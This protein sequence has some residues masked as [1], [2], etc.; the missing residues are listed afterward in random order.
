MTKKIFLLLAIAALCLAACQKPPMLTLNGPTNL[1]ISVTGG[2]SPLTFTANKDWTVRASDSWVHVNPASGEG[3]KNA[4]TVTVT[5]DPNTS[6]D[7]R[8]ATV[9]I[10]SEGLTQAITIKQPAANGL[11]ASPQTINLEAGASTFEVEVQ[12]NVTYQVAIGASW[13][14]QT[15]TKALTS[16]KIV[17]S[18]EAN[19]AFEERSTTITIS[20]GNLASQVINVKQAAAEDPAK[21]LYGAWQMGA[22]ALTLN[23]GGTFSYIAYA[24][25]DEQKGTWTYDGENLTR[26]YEGSTDKEIAKVVLAGEKTW[27]S[28]VREDG[29]GEYRSRFY[30]NY[31]KKGATVLSGTLGDGRWD[32]PRNGIRPAENTISTSYT[33]CMVVEGSTVDLYV[34]AWGY[35]IQGTFTLNDGKM[36][37]ETDDDHIWQGLYIDRNGEYG[38][39]GWSA[40][41]PPS[42]EFESTWDYSYDSM[43]AETFELQYPY[44]YMSVSEVLAQGKK[45]E[46][47]D[48][49]YQVHPYY[50][51]FLIY[52]WGENMREIAYDLRDFDLC[53]TP[54]GTEA[55][56]G[57]IG[58]SPWLYKR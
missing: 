18:A 11:I 48:P 20:G 43:N 21:D 16:T 25:A 32:A 3:A 17:F 44:K 55:F 19:T 37:I 24:D 6:Y 12:A 10:S 4:I 38:S 27:L 57:A 1:E 53:V 8:T 26:T 5:V 40:G 23:E 45:P 54:D 51:K 15:G 29:E 50:L 58:L 9:T 47:Y 30:E 56:G 33:F 46:Q 39:I 49:E 22:T 41:N 31:R 42:D 28:L 14:K 2:S 7:D 52:E 34:P 13:I 35:H 36:H